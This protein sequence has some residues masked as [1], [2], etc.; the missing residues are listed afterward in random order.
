MTVFLAALV[1]HGASRAQVP[2]P[3][4]ARLPKGPLREEVFMASGDPARPV[5]LEVTLFKPGGA[6]PF[7]LAVMNHGATHASASN[8]GERYRFTT[9]AYYFLSR[10]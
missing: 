4:D 6:G 8:R 9:S 2:D 7:P 1:A 5:S 10:G 3:N